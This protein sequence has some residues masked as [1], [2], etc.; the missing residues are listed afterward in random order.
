[1]TIVDPIGVPARI[2]TIMPKVAQ[3]TEINA[4]TIVTDKKLL[5]TL[6]A[7]I[8]GKITSAE[9]RSE[10]T[11]FIAN[12]MMTAI[13]VAIIRLYTFVFTPVALAKDSSKVTEKILL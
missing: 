7:E 5:W 13:K 10:P 1:M 2:D 11:R 4:E 3:T 12:T 9:M 6:M 8:A